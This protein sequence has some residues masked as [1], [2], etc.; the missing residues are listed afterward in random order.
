MREENP[1]AKKSLCENSAKYLDA[2]AKALRVRL[3]HHVCSP[4]QVPKLT[5][6]VR[7]RM[8]VNDYCEFPED[9]DMR[10]YTQGYL[11]RKEKE[12][13]GEALDENDLADQAFPPQYY[14]YKLR[15]VVIHVG[16]AESGHYYSLIK[17]GSEK[18]FEFNDNIVRPFYIRDLADEAFGGEEKMTGNLGSLSKSAKEKHRN[19][20]L[21]FYERVAYF[22]DAGKPIKSLLM[23]EN[24]ENQALDVM[25]PK[26]LQEIRADN[27]KFQMTKYMFDRDY[28]DL[29]QRVL[30][31]NVNTLEPASPNTM[32][33]PSVLN[34]G[35]LSIL[36]FM[37]VILRARD[38]DRL[39]QFLKEVKKAL[40]KYYELSN[41]L[42]NSF[43]EIDIIK[44]FL[45]HCQVPDMKYFTTG[46]IKLALETV[47]Q[48][49]SQQSYEDFKK[50]S[51][52][53]SL[54]NSFV[55]VLY[56]C[57]D[58]YK[59]M[60][61]LFEVFS[62]LAGLGT[63]TKNYLL[64]QRTIGRIIYVI[65]NQKVPN[66]TFKDYRELVNLRALKSDDGLGD[67]TKEDASKKHLESIKSVGEMIDKKKEKMML[68][69]LAVNFNSLVATVAK[70]GLSI[71]MPG[72][73]NEDGS[74][75]QIAFDDSERTILY[76]IEAMKALLK[77][78]NTKNSRKLVSSLIAHVSFKKENLL[79]DII[80]MLYQEMNARDDQALKVYLITLE[81]LMSVQDGLEAQRVNLFSSANLIGNVGGKGNAML[82]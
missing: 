75:V 19:A 47:Y 62:I 79:S 73:S 1:D 35:K 20:Y 60:P 44:E 4:F 48:R 15:G 6:F 71:A 59:M 10:P 29:I 80:K 26:I 69:N 67:P 7:Q 54:T 2:C 43:R 55:Y 16:T 41:W 8:K 65:L 64:E 3:R 76:S 42:L 25:P 12:E 11:R 31:A 5:F 28:S 21:L 74:F 30:K 14:Q 38:R 82:H 61:K 18:W 70:L 34:I 23:N 63:Y 32:P 81:K 77:E 58:Q 36:Y 46:L 78:S 53:V 22:D 50:N 40:A 37:T 27:Y 72:M 24:S 45:V 33:K 17:D 9:L 66:N 52:I 49:D 51:A 68:E 57:E 56:E 39:P 13:A